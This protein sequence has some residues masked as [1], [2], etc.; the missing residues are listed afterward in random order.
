MFSL[1]VDCEA[2]Q[3]TALSS[4]F[5]FVKNFYRNVLVL[6]KCVGQLDATFVCP[7]AAAVAAVVCGRKDSQETKIVLICMLNVQSAGNVFAKIFFTFF[8]R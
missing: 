7:I 4:R 3:S 5:N 8:K 1:V 6:L 2:H